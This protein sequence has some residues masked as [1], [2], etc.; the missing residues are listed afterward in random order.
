[1]TFKYKTDIE[2]QNITWNMNGVMLKHWLMCTLLYELVQY[3]EVFM[4]L[5]FMRYGYT[6]TLV[7]MLFMSVCVVCHFIEM[8]RL[9][10]VVN[11]LIKF[12][13]WGKTICPNLQEK[14]NVWIEEKF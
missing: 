13:F 7:K 8:T 10:K 4:W 2:L 14:W 5:K 12:G 6:K 11:S 1:M 9:C 3:I